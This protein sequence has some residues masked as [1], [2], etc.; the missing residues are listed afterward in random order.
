MSSVLP[1]FRYALLA[2]LM[3]A[4]TAALA[5]TATTQPSPTTREGDMN[6]CGGSPSPSPDYTP[7]QVIRIQLQAMQ[8]NDDPAPDS[9]IATAFKFASPGNRA[10]TGPIEKFARMVKGPLYGAMINH[11]SAE[12]G[13]L[14]ADESNAQQLVKIIGADGQEALYVFILNKQADGPYKDCWM[15]DG[16]VRVRPEDL[17][18]DAPPPEPGSNGDGHEKA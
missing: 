13:Q 6:P 7:Q 16:V 14:R 10:Q 8:H 18:P 15:T 17:Q 12:F 1:G 11:K 4:T 3:L 2:S 5:A 9:G